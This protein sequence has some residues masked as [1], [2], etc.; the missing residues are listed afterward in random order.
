MPLLTPGYKFQRRTNHRRLPPLTLLCIRHRWESEMGWS[1]HKS[2]SPKDSCLMWWLVLRSAHL[3]VP[4]DVG[5]IFSYE[6]LSETAKSNLAVK[7]R[8]YK[9]DGEMGR[10][11]H[12]SRS[13]SQQHEFEKGR[14]R[15]VVVTL[16]TLLST[17]AVL[18]RLYLISK[19]RCLKLLTLRDSMSYIKKKIVA[20]LTEFRVC[21]HA[22]FVCKFALA[23]V[24]FVTFALFYVASHNS[25]GAIE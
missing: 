2:P 9:K 22:A 14:Y 25:I 1:Q 15:V 7:R 21:S 3:A 6:Y 17:M 8:L 13:E 4:S 10:S 11:H 16:R 5:C 23:F 18:L 12:T 19:I 20:Y 24:T